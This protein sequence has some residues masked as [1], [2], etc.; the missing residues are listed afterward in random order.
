[1]TDGSMERIDGV[2]EGHA[3]ESPGWQ[4]IERAILNLYNGLEHAFYVVFKILRR[5]WLGGGLEWERRTVWATMAAMERP[6]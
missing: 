1:M 4:G 6:G 2:L 3:F 5:I